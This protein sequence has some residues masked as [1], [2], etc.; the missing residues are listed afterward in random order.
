MATIKICDRCGLEGVDAT[1]GHA[2]IPR[3]T[4]DRTDRVPYTAY[5]DLCADCIASLQDWM[6]A[7]PVGQK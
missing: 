1:A 7:V 2:Y 5:V 3:R 6:T 4:A